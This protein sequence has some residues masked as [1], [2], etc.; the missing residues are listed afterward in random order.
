MTKDARID[1]SGD[2][3]PLPVMSLAFGVDKL[4][5]AELANIAPETMG[6][7]ATETSYIV[8]FPEDINPFIAYKAAEMAMNMTPELFR[9]YTIE[10]K[11]IVG[12]NGF[13]K[14]APD[15]SINPT[16]RDRPERGP[17]PS[18]LFITTPGDMPGEEAREYALL[19]GPQF[20]KKYM[21]HTNCSLSPIS[22]RK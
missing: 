13:A 8:A 22:E 19:N 7:I 11:L 17:L 5:N 14:M 20:M 1:E 15:G 12:R 10:E 18:V 2:K 4:P 3:R 21:P 6:R 9:R 16:L